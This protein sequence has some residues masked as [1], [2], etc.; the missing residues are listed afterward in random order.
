[1]YC[2]T[3]IADKKLKGILVAGL[4]IK[5]IVEKKRRIWFVKNVK[6][7]FD[8][9]DGLGEFLEVEAIDENG[10]LSIEKLAEQ[11]SSFAVLFAIKD[12]DYIAYSYGDLLLQKEQNSIGTLSGN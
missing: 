7:H 6:I 2:C 1:M 10:N 4:G 5:V 11:C 3:G 9:V 8:K 12:E